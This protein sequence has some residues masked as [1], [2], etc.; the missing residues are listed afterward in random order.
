MICGMPLFC[1]WLPRVCCSTR[2]L[3]RAARSLKPLI[4]CVTSLRRVE[5]W[6]DR[7][8]DSSMSAAVSRAAW[9]LRCGRFRTSSGNTAR[10]LP[11]SPARAVSTARSKPAGWSGF[12][13]DHLGQALIGCPHLA[14]DVVHHGGHC[15][16]GGIVAVRHVADHLGRRQGLNERWRQVRKLPGAG[17]SLATET[18]EAARATSR[19]P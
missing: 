16:G 12:R 7:E 15:A 2:V 13:F 4:A 11:A 17:D 10:P 1:S 19:A 9:A 18:P 5:P 3:M 8:M 14:I 6:L